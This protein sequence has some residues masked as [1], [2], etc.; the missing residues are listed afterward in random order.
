[1]YHF[2]LF[3]FERIRL[4]LETVLRIPPFVPIAMLDQRKF[5]LRKHNLSLQISSNMNRFV[6][7]IPVTRHLPFEANVIPNNFEHTD[8]PNQLLFATILKIA[9]YFVQIF[10]DAKE[11]RKIPRGSFC[12]LHIL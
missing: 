7:S 9:L 3:S 2:S 6:S 10:G 11:S 4:S 12:L 8:H 5:E 1:L